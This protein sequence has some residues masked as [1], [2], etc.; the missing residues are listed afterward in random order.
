MLT[1]SP[2][3][4]ITVDQALQHDFFKGYYTGTEPVRAPVSPFDF[5]FELYNFRIAEFR[6]EFRKEI[7][8]YHS[9]EAYAEYKAMKK[10]H[11]NGALF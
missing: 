1:Y 6:E 10:E 11:P 4:R 2:E 8:L 5:D 9:E 3:E 7:M